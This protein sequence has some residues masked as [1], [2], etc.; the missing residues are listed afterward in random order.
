MNQIVELN[1]VETE[2]VAGGL[3]FLLLA[4]DVAIWSYNAYKLSR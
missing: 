4:A 3:F 2:E 1:A